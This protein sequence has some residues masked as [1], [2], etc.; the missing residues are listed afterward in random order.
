MPLE[1]GDF[2][3]YLFLVVLIVGFFAVF[4]FGM[5][6]KGER[7]PKKM[8]R[9]NPKLKPPAPPQKKAK[10]DDPC[11]NK[12]KG[13]HF[14]FLHKELDKKAP[15]PDEC[16]QCDLKLECLQGKKPK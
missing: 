9:Q 1:Y 5:I 11:K 13:F 10:S 16:L 4:T 6:L 7:K 15:I 12:D 8:S 14:G 3:F 2:L